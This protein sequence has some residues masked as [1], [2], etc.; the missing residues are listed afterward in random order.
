M[1]KNSISVPTKLL[2]Y[3]TFA[4]LLTVGM[5][6][7]APILT[8]IL[9]SIFTALL[10]TPFVRWLKR[11]GIPGGLSVI[12]VTILFILVVAI[13]GIMVAEA[14]IQ[15]GNQI[16]IYQIN[17]MGF[18][19]SLTHHPPS[20]YL[21][22]Q[23]GFSVNSI[24]SGIASVIISIMKSAINGLVSAGT[25]IGIIIFT[26][27][28]LLIN[29]ANT[30]EK[31]ESELENQSEVQRR[32]SKFGKNLVGFIVIRAETNLITAVGITIFFL[33]GRIDF[34]ILWGVL[35]FLLSYIP[36]IGL[37][38][39]AIPPTMLAL[40][41]YGP[42]G[43]LV[44]LIII[45]G[46]DGLAENVLFPSL[47]GKG[48]RLSPAFL[49]IALIYWNYVLGSA[50]ILLSIPLTMVLKITL[51]SFEETKWMARLMGPPGDSE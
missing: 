31:T 44:V 9:F 4:V 50:G 10:L 27:A 14:A 33:I 19:D 13:I 7:I 24:L 39:A 17:L 8:T 29:A 21:S 15:F 43:A 22:S 32:M 12:L 46:F 28:F 25:T 2:I 38:I 49:F 26:T 41:K 45:F 30:P 1:N 35:I 20:K 36:Y 16:P 47:A 40:F 6:E 5:K 42:L 34:A 3:S 48:L 51:E 11:K 37:V 18:I 23:G